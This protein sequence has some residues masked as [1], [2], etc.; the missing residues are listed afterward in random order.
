MAFKMT[1]SPA[2]LGWLG[3]IVEKRTRISPLSS[4]DSGGFTSG[5]RGELVA[6]GVI[7]A[8]G[9]AAPNSCAAL[10]ALAGANSFCRLRF[11]GG[12]L[13]VEKT[14]YFH[15]ATA[16]SLENGDGRFTVEYPA[17]NEGT[18]ESLGQFIGESGIVNSD[19][20]AILGFQEALVLAAMIDLY[21]R[22]VLRS[23]ADGSPPAG[24]AYEAKDIAEAIRSAP[25]TPQ[26]VASVLKKM[27]GV[28][29]ELAE[30]EAAGGLI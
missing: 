11:S 8:D 1:L 4:F 30:D 22:E 10:E 14:I 9:K 20:H 27:K 17:Q 19:F 12:P 24:R 16:L 5:E 28:N 26:W 21:R 2:G 23:Y 3:G 13:A 6:Q 29:A 15:G 18:V 25:D 7:D